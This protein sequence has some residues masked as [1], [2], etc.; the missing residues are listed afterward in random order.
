MPELQLDG[1]SLNITS[2]IK[3]FGKE[4]VL[5]KDQ[6]NQEQFNVIA[7][8]YIDATLRPRAVALDSVINKKIYGKN[9]TNLSTDICLGITEKLVNQNRKVFL[10]TQGIIIDFGLTGGILGQSVYLD[11]SGYLSLTPS[12]CKIGYLIKTTTPTV[13][14][15]IGT[16]SS[17][18][19]LTIAFDAIPKPYIGNDTLLTSFNKFKRDFEMNFTDVTN[20]PTGSGHQWYTITHNNAGTFVIGGYGG[21]PPPTRIQYSTDNGITWN[22]ATIL[23]GAI[24][25]LNLWGNIVFV[26]GIFIASG[27]N[28]NA[29]IAT[30]PDGITWTGQA[31]PEALNSHWSKVAYGNGVYVSVSYDAPDPNRVMTSSDAI[32][33]IQGTLPATIGWVDVAFGNGLF[34]AIGGSGEVITSPDGITWTSRT[35]SESAQW[36]NIEFIN[37]N[38]Y[39]VGNSGTANAMVSPDG[40]NWTSIAITPITFAS[41]ITLGQGSYIVGDGAAGHIAILDYNPSLQL[42]EK[43]VYNLVHEKLL[44]YNDTIYAL[45]TTQLYRIPFNAI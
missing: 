12:I 27:V 33:W 41:T 9:F 22:A 37:G 15:N 14:I 5:T 2:K 20:L 35:P 36:V 11:T 43:F 34:V 18:V 16:E 26:N 30:S 4:T 28:G 10:K 23:G 7:S 32:N 8:E 25:T 24:Y 19:D 42:K 13:F 17:N 21:S 3:I 45:T 1:D 6:H 44:F 39:V 29:Q 31:T 40:I 38:F